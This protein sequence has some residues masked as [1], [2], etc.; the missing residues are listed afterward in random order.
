VTELCFIVFHHIVVKT[1]LKETRF[2]KAVRTDS[3]V[4]TTFGVRESNV[5][6]LLHAGKGWNERET[7]TRR[8]MS[9]AVGGG[10]IAQ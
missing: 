6:V 3:V 4:S 7:M 1:L 9:E 2:L 8:S 5:I 10:V